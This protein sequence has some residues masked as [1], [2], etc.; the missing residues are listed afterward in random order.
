MNSSFTCNCRIGWP[1]RADQPA[2]AALCSTVL[3]IAYE[4]VEIRTVSGLKP[5]YRGAK[6]TG[7]PEAII[8]EIR[9]VLT[10]AFTKD[11]QEK[12][13]NIEAL[14]EKTKTLW[15]EGGASWKDTR[16]FIADYLSGENTE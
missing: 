6:P 2:C 4:L 3:N 16:R 5:L 14:R 1:I 13:Q 12:R 10:N 9:T 7:T 15:K 11:G 8:E